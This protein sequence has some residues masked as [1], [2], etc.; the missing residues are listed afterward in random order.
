MVEILLSLGGVIIGGAIGLGGTWLQ[1]KNQRHLRRREEIL[2][3]ASKALAAAEETHEV[4]LEHGIR[5]SFPVE[6]HESFGLTGIGTMTHYIQ[7]QRKLQLALHELS[8]LIRD[9]EKES[10]QLLESV[11]IWGRNSSESPEEWDKYYDARDALLER[12][13]Q[14]LG[15]E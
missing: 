8:L 13:R 1:S 5:T 12:V 6:T 3:V 4:I 15:T 2:P 11:S 9:I 7:S 14:H 10:K